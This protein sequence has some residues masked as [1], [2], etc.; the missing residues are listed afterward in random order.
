MFQSAELSLQHE[1][2]AAHPLQLKVQSSSQHS[3]SL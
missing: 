3:Q 2:Q 1:E